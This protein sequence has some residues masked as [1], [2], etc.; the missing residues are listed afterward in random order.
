MAAQV[1]RFKDH[2]PR[3]QREA[4]R[5]GIDPALWDRWRKLSPKVR[6][7]TNP[8]DY[9]TGKTVRTQL[10]APLLTAATNKVL[11]IHTIRGARRADMSPVR[12]TAVRRNLDHPGAGMT[13]AKLRRIMRMSPQALAAEVDDSLSRSYSSGDRSPFWYEKRG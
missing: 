13:N 11:A 4:L 3:W 7:A 6:K 9:S 2:S 5:K 1:K 12:I 8:T 10:R